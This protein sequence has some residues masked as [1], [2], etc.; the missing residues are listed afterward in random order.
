VDLLGRALLDALALILRGDPELL[1]IA[2]LSLTVSL[3]AT[4]LATL[5]GIPAG[6][7]LATRRYRGRRLVGALVNTGMGLPPVVVG[8]TVALFLWRSGPFGA[9]GLIYTPQAMVIAQFV[10]AAPLAAGLTRSALELL[11]PELRNALH[12]DGAGALAEGRELVWAALPQVRVAV[13]AAFGRAVAEVGAS[14]IVGGDIIGHTR[15]LTTAIAAEVR[16]G[17]FSL[18]LALGIVLLMLAFIVNLG[19]GG[20]GRA[21]LARG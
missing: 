14:L 13:A 16:R 18:A 20:R 17:D 8:L 21:A 11:D 3:S 9:L 2:A 6:I 10:V 5:A 7:L 12:V 15:I 1:R 4:V 19:L